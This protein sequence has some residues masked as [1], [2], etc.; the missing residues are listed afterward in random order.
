MSSHV[1][2]FQY[3][4]KEEEFWLPSEATAPHLDSAHS[5]FHRDIT[6]VVIMLFYFITK[7][8]SIRL[9]PREREKGLHFPHQ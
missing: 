3:G 2:I 5:C 6:N 7:F 8:F 1:S 4:S 9:F